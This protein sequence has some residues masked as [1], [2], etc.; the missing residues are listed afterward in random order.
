MRLSV[1]GLVGEGFFV[2][3]I[4]CIELFCVLSIE[5]CV[6][7]ILIDLVILVWILVFRVFSYI[8][9]WWLFR[10]FG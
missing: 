4:V 1:L 8:L 7:D 3:V 5:L 6:V 10:G 9:F 2:E